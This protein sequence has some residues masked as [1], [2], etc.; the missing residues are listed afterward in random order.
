MKKL[1]NDLYLTFKFIK[2]LGSFDYDNEKDVFVITLNKK[3]NL[4]DS[5]SVLAHEIIHY[6]YE[7]KYFTCKNDEKVAYAIEKLLRKGIKILI[8]MH[9][10]INL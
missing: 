9:S 6:L 4:T 10:K 1:K 3:L 8:K 5:I 7:K 2:T